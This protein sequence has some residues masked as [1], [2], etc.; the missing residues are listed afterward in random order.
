[1]RRLSANSGGHPNAQMKIA[2]TLNL[3]KCIASLSSRPAFVNA[4]FRCRALLWFSGRLTM[5]WPTLDHNINCV[6]ES[7]PSVGIKL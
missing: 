5:L 7:L 1:M 6:H 4:P 3:V 2:G